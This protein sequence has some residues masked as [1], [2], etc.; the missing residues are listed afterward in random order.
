MF[1]Y[2]ENGSGKGNIINYMKLRLFICC[3]FLLIPS[4]YGGS[5]DQG[6]DFFL[7]NSPVEAALYFEL[8]L[9]DDPNNENIIM[10]LGLSYIQSGLTAKGISSFIRGADLNGIQK[11]RFYLNAGNAYF[12]QS[13]F[14]N[15][16]VYYN[17][18]IDEGLREKGDALLNRA[19]ILMSSEDLSGAVDVYRLYLIAKPLSEQKDKILRLIALIEN[20]L[21]AEALESEKLAAEAERLRLQEEQRIATEAADAETR[22]LAE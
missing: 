2:S 9:K 1:I 3:F 11:G 18:I 6:K 4:I 21:E 22:R 5:F 19:N 10:Y 15:A 20:K 8:A 13:D 14:T 16:L 12:S 17:L 7:N